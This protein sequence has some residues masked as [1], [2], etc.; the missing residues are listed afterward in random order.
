MAQEMSDEVGA[1]AQRYRDAERRTYI[2]TG[3]E[4]RMREVF[5]SSPQIEHEAKQAWRT[6]EADIMERFR[7]MIP[8]QKSKKSEGP[9]VFEVHHEI[10]VAKECFLIRL[11]CDDTA[12]V[13]ADFTRERLGLTGSFDEFMLSATSEDESPSAS[14]L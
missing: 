2:D 6:V 7:S 11:S 3:V 1:A 10:T 12:Q 9:K 5:A 8:T 4:A 14:P 13:A